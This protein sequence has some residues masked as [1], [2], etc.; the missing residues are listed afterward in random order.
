MAT[1]Q[2]SEPGE[3]GGSENPERYSVETLSGGTPNG[4]STGPHLGLEVLDSFQGQ[5]KETRLSLSWPRNPR[6]L[7]EVSALSLACEYGP[8]VLGVASEPLSS[9]TSQ[10]CTRR[11][12]R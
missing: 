3:G 5:K 6:A 11:A 4:A 2:S 9:S 10:T 12:P 7:C 8:N 1:D